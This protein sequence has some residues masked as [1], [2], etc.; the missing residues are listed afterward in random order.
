MDPC[1]F[2]LAYPY[3]LAI[4]VAFCILWLIT[5]KR[6]IF[7]SLVTILAGYSYI[8]SLI[9][10]TPARTPQTA[11]ASAFKVITFNI[12]SLNGAGQSIDRTA[13]KNQIRDFLANQHA[14]V[15]C[16]QEFYLLGD[17]PEQTVTEFGNGLGM[18][19]HYWKN[20]QKY[21]NPRRINGLVIFS[22]Y[23]LSHT[24]F[25]ERPTDSYTYAIHADLTIGSR[26]VTLYNLHLQSIRFGKADYQFYEQ[27]K[28]AGKDVGDL[29]EG[30]LRMLWKMKKASILRSHQADRLADEIKTS[31][32]PVL[33]VGDFN[34]PPFSYTLG[35]LKK[36]LYDA[37]KTAGR[38]LPGSTYVGKF[39]AYR[40]DYL[41]HSKQLSVKEYIKYKVV[42]SDHY[43]VGGVVYFK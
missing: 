43:P 36:N 31:S 11:A 8:T 35:T 28:D 3:I 15:V 9:P 6:Y 39:P 13:M 7:I 24:G 42:F 12:H 32:H 38:G 30:S 40:I 19:F 34:D 37:Y 29:S 2:G 14:D 26:M 41:L 1:V 25:I 22:K 21:L 20:Y 23:P 27:L 17:D 16:L 33:V 5:W 4:N 18:P 10:L